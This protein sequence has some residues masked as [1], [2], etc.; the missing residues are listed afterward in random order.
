MRKTE[1]KRSSYYEQLLK[2]R[3]QLDPKEFFKRTSEACRLALEHYE[4]QKKRAEVN[5]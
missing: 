2:L 5:Q 4:Q 3:R 1:F